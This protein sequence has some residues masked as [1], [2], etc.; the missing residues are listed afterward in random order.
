MKT[1]AEILNELLNRQGVSVV[2]EQSVLSVAQLMRFKNIGA[3]AVMQENHLIGVVSERDMLNK[4]LSFGVDPRDV[5]AGEIMSRNLTLTSP[6][7]TSKD[8]L[9]K[10]RNAHCRHLPVVDKGCFVGMISLRDVL[11]LDEAELLDTYFWGRS[12]RSKDSHSTRHS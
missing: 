2:P 9:I 6:D 8:C 1:V 4:V 10:M 5:S 7:E 12:V 11:G 3:V